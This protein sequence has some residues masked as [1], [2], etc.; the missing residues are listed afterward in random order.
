MSDRAQAALPRLREAMLQAAA[1]L[2]Q[3]G[4]QDFAARIRTETKP[5]ALQGDLYMLITEVMEWVA[6][7]A[8]RP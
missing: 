4:E 2:E 8:H 6:R 7:H 1:A 3:A 5:T